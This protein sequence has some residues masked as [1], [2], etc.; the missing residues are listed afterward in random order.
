M[1]AE[2]AFGEYLQ[3]L[4]LEEKPEAETNLTAKDVIAGA[5]ETLRMMREKAK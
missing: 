4:G 3:K 5:E 1:G 2:I